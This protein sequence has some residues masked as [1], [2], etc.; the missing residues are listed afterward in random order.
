MGCY[1]TNSFVSDG[2]D[3]LVTQHSHY[4]CTNANK[5][6]CEAHADECIWNKKSGCIYVT[7]SPTPHPTPSPLPRQWYHDSQDGRCKPDS[8]DRPSWLTQVFDFYDECCGS[9][10]DKKGCLDDY[11]K[12]DI[13]ATNDDGE[14]EEVK[15][16]YLD[17]GD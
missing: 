7:Q 6:S 8:S 1:V 15:E 14:E 9:S 10:W 3:D 13:S 11:Y 2:G 4:E 17:T 16:Y 12:Y 5:A